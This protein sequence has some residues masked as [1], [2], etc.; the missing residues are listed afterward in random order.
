MDF[1]FR[2][3]RKPPP[4]EQVAREQREDAEQ[5]R[6]SR[7]LALGFTIPFALL[8]GPIG[9]WL[10][11]SWLDKLLGTS[12]WLIILILLGT[13]AGLKMTIDLLSRL[14]QK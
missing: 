7:G 6:L 14:N 5:V 12:Y 2:Y 4:P 11:G 8:S 10:L 13:A 3:N 1:R 9:G